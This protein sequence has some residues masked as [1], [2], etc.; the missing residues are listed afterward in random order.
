[1]AF[2]AGS[3]RCYQNSQERT[4]PVTGVGKGKCCALAV[5]TGVRYAPG[6]QQSRLGTSAFDSVGCVH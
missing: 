4:D 5:S 6:Q 2:A 3:F 1:M